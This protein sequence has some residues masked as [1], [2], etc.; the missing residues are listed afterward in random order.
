M[1]CTTG[2]NPPGLGYETPES[3]QTLKADK[4]IN[5]LEDDLQKITK[6]LHNIANEL[7]QINKQLRRNK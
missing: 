5:A 3:L 4:N 7:N 6:E 2:A 1:R